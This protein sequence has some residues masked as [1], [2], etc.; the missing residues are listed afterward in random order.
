M[1]GLLYLWVIGSARFYVLQM[2][3]YMN[4]LSITHTQVWVN[5]AACTWR[6][7]NR[8]KPLECKQHEVRDFVGSAHERSPHSLCLVHSH[9]SSRWSLGHVKTSL[10]ITRWGDRGTIAGCRHWPS[11][12]DWSLRETLSGLRAETNPWAPVT[13]NSLT[14][15]A[16]RLKDCVI[17]FWVGPNKTF[18]C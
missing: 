11:R 1:L 13:R 7:P 4:I 17:S 6:H 8:H 9:T 10:C 15:H 18:V 14:L 5:F 3:M 2:H 16:S 12:R